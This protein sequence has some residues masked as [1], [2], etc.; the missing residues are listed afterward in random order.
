VV[1]KDMFDIENRDYGDVIPIKEFIEY[2]DEGAI[3][4]SDG[5]GYYVTDKVWCRSPELAFTVEELKADRR[6][7]GFTHVL[8]CNK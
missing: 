8:W 3:I 7:H 2:V 1:S 6:K 4:E 5:C